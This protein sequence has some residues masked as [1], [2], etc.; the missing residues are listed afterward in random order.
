MTYTLAVI[1]LALLAEFGL[2]CLFGSL[3]ARARARLDQI[4]QALTAWNTYLESRRQ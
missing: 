3:M 2:S 1:A 4:E